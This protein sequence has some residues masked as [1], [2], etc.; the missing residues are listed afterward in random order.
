VTSADCVTGHF[1]DLGSQIIGTATGACCPDYPNNTIQVD[2]EQGS[3]VECCG[4][5][6]GAQ[7]C[8]TIGRAMGI[9]RQTQLYGATIAA[10][11]KKTVDPNTG[12]CTFWGDLDAGSIAVEYYPLQLGY[13][14]TLSAPGVCFG[15]YYTNPHF[16][17]SPCGGPFTTFIVS[18]FPEEDG[19]VTV[20]GG[21]G[22]IPAAVTLSGLPNSPLS[23]TTQPGL[24]GVI[25]GQVVDPTTG[26]PPLIPWSNYCQGGWAPPPGNNID[27]T[28][29]LPGVATLDTVSITAGGQSIDSQHEPTTGPA[30]FVGPGSS[31]TLGPGPVSI[32][33]IYDTS[34]GGSNET[35]DGI[36]CI[37][38]PNLWSSLQDDPNATAPVLSIAPQNQPQHTNLFYSTS[39]ATELSVTHCNVNLSAGPSL[40]SGYGAFDSYG[41]GI[42]FNGG[43]LSSVALGSYYGTC[44]GEQAATLTFGSD[45]MPGVIHCMSY[46]GIIMPY[47]FDCDGNI[48]TG[49][50]TVQIPGAS[51]RYNNGAGVHIQA[52]TLQTSG[53]NTQIVTNDVGVQIDG[54]YDSEGGQTG[55]GDQQVTLGSGTVVA[56][57]GSLKIDQ[58]GAYPSIMYS[59]VQ[60]G[61]KVASNAG[62]DVFNQNAGGSA[63]DARGL[64]WTEYDG[65]TT[66][67]ATCDPSCFQPVFPPDTLNAGG[68]A[69]IGCNC[70]GPG[71]PSKK[72][73]VMPDGLDVVVATGASVLVSGGSAL[74]P[75]YC[76]N[77]AQGPL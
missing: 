55:A 69:C 74:D 4:E 34:P 22:P 57:N 42:G 53:S 75:S 61:N 19:G 16:T 20:G 63:V 17:A 77:L 27:P 24:P 41:I 30:L 68:T 32:N 15:A 13:G 50:P 36:D 54:Q 9:I 26:F 60:P 28:V 5:G 39:M 64:A 46:D 65:G 52:G 51:I 40:G 47:Q 56:C 3:D 8:A 70:A 38:A 48:E 18:P 35:L 25:L 11:A 67:T 33:L 58:P 14:V 76:A 45:A 12:G 44:E 43:F 1:C 62:A 2:N 49:G 6:G 73:T 23:I 7:A 37:G 66:A 10:A 71:C 21:A 59:Y 29:L 31:L 72:F